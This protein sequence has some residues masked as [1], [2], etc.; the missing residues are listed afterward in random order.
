MRIGLLT[1]HDGFNF[2]A[3]LQCYSLHEKLKELGHDVEIVHYKN[4]WFWFKEF[5]HILKRDGTYKQNLVKV[6]KFW[7]AHRLFNLTNFTSD[8]SEFKDVFDAVDFGSDEIWNVNNPA[9]GYDLSYFGKGFG[10]SKLIAYA[11]S[12]GSTKASDSKLDMLDEYIN[13]FHRIAVRDVNSKGIVS[14]ISGESVKLV[15]DPTFL[16]DQNKWVKLPIEKDYILVYSQILLPEHINYL[17]DYSNKVGKKIISVGFK[18]DIADQNIIGIDP[19]EFLGYIKNAHYVFTTMFH[20]TIFS[21][22][23]NRNFTIFMDPYRLQKFSYL[24]ERLQLQDRVYVH[25]EHEI[26]NI[27]M[28]SLNRL[29]Q[30]Y[31]EDGENYLKEALS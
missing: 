1:F 5:V 4:R 29:I 27:D 18:V 25:G 13:R 24:L 15:P 23:L 16:M 12:F 2:G 10:N 8:V 6:G 11:P 28:D 26:G 7:K 30:G 20:G 9:F 17:K 22:L 3:F 14:K 21:I 31:K 19:F